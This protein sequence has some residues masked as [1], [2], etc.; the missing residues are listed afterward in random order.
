MFNW[1]RNRKQTPPAAM[2]DPFEQLSTDYENRCGNCHEELEAGDKYCRHCGTKR[3]EGKFEPYSNLIACIYGPEPVKRR[4][5]CSAC[6]YQW[7]TCLMMDDEKY[8]PR[9]GAKAEIIKEEYD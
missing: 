1:F 3:G 7:E 6:W 9:C 2:D 4:H 8:C 5:R